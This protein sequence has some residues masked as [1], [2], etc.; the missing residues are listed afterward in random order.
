MGILDSM[1]TGYFY[2]DPEDPIY[3]DHFPGFPVVP[4]S[5]IIHAFIKAVGRLMEEERPCTP[6]G[7]RFKRFIS[8]GQYAFR[9]QSR[10]DGRMSCLLFDRNDA[11][12]EGTL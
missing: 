8:P 7:F 11:V 9:I 6:T 2:F 5:L 12:V 1:K 10:S 4:G 3:R